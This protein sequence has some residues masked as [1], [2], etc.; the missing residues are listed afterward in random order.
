M[1]E[2]RRPA[3][4]LHLHSSFAPGGKELR[5]VQLINAFGRSAEHEIVSADKNQYGASKAIKPGLRVRYPRSFPS[6]T[7]KPTPRRLLK[8]AQAMADYDLILTYNWGAMDAAMA[9]TAFAE[10]MGLPPLIHHED[11]FNSDEA[12]KLKWSRNW[13]RRIA[14]GRSAA[15]VVPSHILG[16]IARQTWSQPA[17]RVKRI[18]NGIDVSAFRKKPKRSALPRLIKRPGEMWLGTMAGLREVKRLDRLVEVVGKLPDN[19]HLV[20]FGEG[21]ER[22]AI[23]ETADRYEISD[24]VHLPGHVKDPAK[25]IGLLDIFALSSDSEQFPISVLE[26]MAAGLPVAAPDVGDI[27]AMVAP[28]NEEFIVPPGDSE[29]LIQAVRT[30]SSDA[31]LRERIGMA[32]KANVTAEYG[33]ARMIEAYRDLYN[34]FLPA[35]ARLQA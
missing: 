31:E 10:R 16:R 4:I 12:K 35:H 6:L 25:V 33:E 34:R 9:H 13:Y 15:V 26:A 32:N 29:A 19:W 21:P 24:R 3:R 7:G 28:E 17:D 27:F 1:S 5:S 23:L 20:I 8:M 11:G 14:L 30:L 2:A 22:E 18:P